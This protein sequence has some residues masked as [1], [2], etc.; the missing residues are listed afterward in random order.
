MLLLLNLDIL[1]WH[2]SNAS[3]ALENMLLVNP[4][5]SFLCCVV[6]CNSGQSLSY[7]NINNGT[8]KG[9]LV[10]MNPQWYNFPCCCLS[11]RG[12]TIINPISCH[13]KQL[14]SEK[15]YWWQKLMHAAD[16]IRTIKQLRRLTYCCFFFLVLAFPNLRCWLVTRLWNCS[17]K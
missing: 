10:M 1:S 8:N 13:N 3:Y 9:S 14:F 7:Y 4:I 2:L 16:R 12:F 15:I 11:T 5:F 17:C 6:S